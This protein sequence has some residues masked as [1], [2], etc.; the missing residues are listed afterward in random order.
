MVWRPDLYA[1]PMDEPAVAGELLSRV[2]DA[3]EAASPLEA[4]E[5]V[6]G[7]LAATLGAC[8]A[9]MLIADMS[10]GSRCAPRRLRSFRR[11]GAV[12]GGGCSLR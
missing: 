1:C 2:L 12:A 11:S 10:G 9:F 8:A 4:V 3:A 6:T 7:A 5:G